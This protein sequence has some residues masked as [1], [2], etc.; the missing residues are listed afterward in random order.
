MSINHGLSKTEE[1]TIWLG[2]KKRCNNPS[3]K[4]YKHYGGRG[5]KICDRWLDFS[6]F[7]KDMGKRPSSMYSIDRIDN[8]GDY[9]PNNCRWATMKEQAVN[10]SNSIVKGVSLPTLAK[11]AGLNYSS[12]FRR[13]KRGV[14]L[15]NAL[16]P[17]TRGNIKYCQRGHKLEGANIIYK[18]DGRRNSRICVNLNQ[19]EYRK[20]HKE[21]AI[22][23]PISN[24]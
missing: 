24:R 13:L 3:C 15:E 20:R 18:R 8:N 1:Y 17:P 23:T 10:K 12:V 19:I 22:L 7:Y 9:E 2:M 16:S 6:N 21:Y 14:N 5:I 4:A 11:E